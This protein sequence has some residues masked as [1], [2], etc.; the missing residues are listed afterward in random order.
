MKDQ[1]KT[2]D[3][4]LAE[5]EELRKRVVAL[6]GIDAE[7]RASVET[8]SALVSLLRLSLESLSLEEFLGRT[9]D[10]L[11][12]L[13]WIRLESKG[14][15][16]LVEDNRQMLIMKAQRG[17]AEPLLT[18]CRQV[19]IG[20]CLCG[21]AAEQRQVVFS[22]RVDERHVTR[23]SEM[24][25]HGHYCIPIISQDSVL[26]VINLYI[27]HGHERSPIEETFLIA[28]ADV[29]AGIVKRRRAEEALERERQSLWRMLQ[30]SDHERQIIS[31]DIHDG[32]AQYLA[33]ARMQFQSHDVFRENSP[34]EAQKAYETGVELV[35]QAHSETR[36]LI[37]EVRPP[38]IDEIGLET[39]VAHLVHEQRRHGGPKIEFRSAVQFG[40]L[41]STLENAL[42]RIVQ[43]ALTNACKHSA[44]KNVAV[45][46]AQEGQEV[47]LEVRDWGTG[48]DP[49]AVG[50]GH[51]GVEGIRQRVR[52]LGGRLTIESTPDSGTRVQVAVPIVERQNEE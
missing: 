52:L 36:R 8:Q 49:E 22:G 48:F 42:Y 6:D 17:L 20:R 4:L 16:F 1:E 31:Y 47:R 18:K 33:G 35:R 46:L 13:P 21:A 38:V 3:Q 28:V 10:L 25:P 5:N 34:L 29:L 43:E 7:L 24:P 32:L 14:A 27:K 26:G 11:V 23:Y 39:A 45:A 37:S 44:S 40:R 30:A 2:R 15:V 12:S 41:P 50:K 51:F 19:P 9:L